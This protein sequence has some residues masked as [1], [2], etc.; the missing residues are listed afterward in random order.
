MY[1]KNKSCFFYILGIPF[2]YSTNGKSFSEHNRLTGEV[3]ELT[4]S[5]FP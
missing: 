2:A 5:E 3:K 4:M 1:I